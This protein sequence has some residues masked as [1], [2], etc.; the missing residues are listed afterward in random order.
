VSKILTCRSVVHNKK[1][2]DRT[3]VPD[4]DSSVE[5]M[6]V[7]WKIKVQERR[8]VLDADSAAEVI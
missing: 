8:L 5:V 1:R 7:K 4:A 2:Q 3:L 6:C